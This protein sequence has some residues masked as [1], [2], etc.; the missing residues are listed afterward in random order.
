M[1]LT[2]QVF[3]MTAI[4][5]LG[6]VAMAIVAKG[7]RRTWFPIMLVCCVLF[8]IALLWSFRGSMPFRGLGAAFILGA[9]ECLGLTFASAMALDAFGQ[10]S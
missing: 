2:S 7:Y 9:L 8:H 3:V 5:L 10:L 4:A 6:P 1:K